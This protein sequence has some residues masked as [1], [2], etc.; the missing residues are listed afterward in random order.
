MK[1][2]THMLN[3]GIQEAGLQSDIWLP[4]VLFSFFT[5]STNAGI[6]KWL[7]Y[8]DKWILFPIIL[9]WRLLNKNYNNQ[10]VHFHVCDHSNSPYLKY[11]PN[12]RAGITCHDVLAIRGA[13]GY[14]DAYCTASRFG[15]I[16]QNWILHHLSRAKVLASVSHFTLRQL[17]ELDTNKTNSSKNWCVIHNAFNDK[18]APLDKQKVNALLKKAGLFDGVPYILHVGS[19]LPRKNRKMLIDMLDSLGDNWNGAVCFA[20]QAL[21]KELIDHAISLNLQKRIISIIKPDH[22][23]LVALYNGCEAFIFPSFS[24]GFGWPVIEAQACGTPVIASDVD[25]MPEVSGGAALHANPN[26]PQAFANAFLSLKDEALKT[27]LIEKGFENI[28]RFTPA[29]MIESY[30]LLHGLK[31]T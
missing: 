22:E 31:K 23:T 2:F 13:L 21:D 16:L 17:D 7:G 18:F 30:L 26:D 3:S 28:H 20:G 19:R 12:N 10:N 25:P 8:I 24:E 4:V 9:R 1:K 6:G 14:P 11:L 5:K 27:K 15:K 29:S